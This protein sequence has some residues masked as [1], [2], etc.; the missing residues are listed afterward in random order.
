MDICGEGV[1]MILHYHAVVL[2]KLY[3][4]SD[5]MQPIQ[6]ERSIVRQ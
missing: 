6:D 2:Y 1:Y 5:A 3:K 4:R